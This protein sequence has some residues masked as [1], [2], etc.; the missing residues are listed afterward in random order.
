MNSHSH[1]K[2]KEAVGSQGPDGAGGSILVAAKMVF[3]CRLKMFGVS[4][5]IVFISPAVME[6]VIRHRKTT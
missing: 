3:L 5:N 2:S 6:S 4:E 1:L